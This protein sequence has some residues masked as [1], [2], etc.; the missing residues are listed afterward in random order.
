MASSQRLGR[1]VVRVAL[2]ESVLEA[3]SVD[4]GNVMVTRRFSCLGQHEN[5]KS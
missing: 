5:K 2:S 1:S 4:F 3:C